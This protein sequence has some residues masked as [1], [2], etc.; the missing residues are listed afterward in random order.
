MTGSLGRMKLKLNCS[1]RALWVSP[2]AVVVVK[3][4]KSTC[5]TAQENELSNQKREVLQA[6]SAEDACP[7]QFHFLKGLY[8]LQIMASSRDRL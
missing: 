3:P 7:T 1:I 4:C 8:S 2:G 6:E 5:S